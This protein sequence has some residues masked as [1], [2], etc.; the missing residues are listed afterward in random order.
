MSSV[1]VPWTVAALAA[2]VFAAIAHRA[3]RSRA[4][5]GLGSGLFALVVTTIIW[6]VGHAS[7]I[8]FSDLER[9]GLRIR[10]TVE[11]LIVIVVCAGVFAFSVRGA[12]APRSEPP[13]KP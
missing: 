10:W 7:D 5:W 6:G 4:L 8:P 13:R 2:A 3:G 9:T 1:I 12:P 11:A